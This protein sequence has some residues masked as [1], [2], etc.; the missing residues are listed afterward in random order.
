MLSNKQSKV[1]GAPKIRDLDVFP[2]I[3]FANYLFFSNT[4]CGYRQNGRRNWA[5][6]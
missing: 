5:E 6:I 4:E 3:D 2:F 1:C